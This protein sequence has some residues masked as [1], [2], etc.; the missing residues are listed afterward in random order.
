MLKYLDSLEN[1]RK[2]NKL[3]LLYKIRNNLLCI[4][5]NGCLE[6]ADSR[7]RDASR[8]YE[9]K[10][11]KTELFKHSFFINTPKIWNNLQS[12]IKDTPLEHQNP[13]GVLQHV[14]LRLHG[15]PK[16]TGI[17]R[18]VHIYTVTISNA[19]I[20][21]QTKTWCKQL[22]QLRLRGNPKLMGSS[23]A[24]LHNQTA[25]QSVLVDLGPYRLQPTYNFVRPRYKCMS[26]FMPCGAHKS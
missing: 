22:V 2:M 26:G 14:Q 16:L 12:V 10:S 11:A 5:E 3:T 23:P 24:H 6:R 8:N 25:I 1:R 13:V 20:H 15:N 4:K 18:F 9:L 7:T 17:I 21:Q 19:I